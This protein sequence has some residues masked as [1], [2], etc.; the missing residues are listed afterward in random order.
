MK[1][2]LSGPFGSRESHICMVYQEDPDPI[3]TGLQKLYL[4]VAEEPIPPEILELLGKLD[5]ADT[6]SGSNNKAIVHSPKA[7][8]KGISKATRWTWTQDG[9]GK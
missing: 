4:G 7:F 2:S 9:M 1:A 8:S 5:Q 3:V 6:T